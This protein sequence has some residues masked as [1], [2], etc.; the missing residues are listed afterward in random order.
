MIETNDI[1]VYSDLALVPQEPNPRRVVV[2]VSTDFDLL[3]V[4]TPGRLNL[5]LANDN[6]QRTVHVYQDGVEKFKFDFFPHK[7]NAAF[8]FRFA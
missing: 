7:Q 1:I 5:L 4:N 8:D 6:L 2:P 3:T